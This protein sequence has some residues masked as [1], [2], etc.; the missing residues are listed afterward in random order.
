MNNWKEVSLK[1]VSKKINYGY[2]ASSTEENTGVK[3]LRITD[4]ASESIVWEKVPYCHISDSEYEKNK[5]ENGDIVIART[6]ATVGYAKM[7]R[8]LQHKSVFASYLVRFKIKDG[9]DRNFVGSIIES[10]VFKNYIQLI[11]GGAA[12]PNANSKDLGSFKFFLPP[13]PEQ[14]QIATII[15]AYDELIESNNQANSLLRQ[16]RDLLLPR[17]ISGKLKVKG[18][19]EAQLSAT[20]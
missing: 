19:K 20:E 16:T 10:D 14:K 17:L 11:A 7:I 9:V 12:Q 8:N 15:S 4:I 6:G 3:L 1:S 5:L 13:H 2:T 18:I